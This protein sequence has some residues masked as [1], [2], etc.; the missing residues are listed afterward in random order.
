MEGFT[1][2]PVGVRGVGELGPSPMG[3]ILLTSTTGGEIEV[4]ATR[5]VVAGTY[6]GTGEMGLLGKGMVAKGEEGEVEVV[7]AVGIRWVA[8]GTGEV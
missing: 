3:L 1:S 8:E 7:L 5:A 4:G 6:E 2:R